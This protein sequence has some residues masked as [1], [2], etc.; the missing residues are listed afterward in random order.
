MAG[1]GR[2]LLVA[3]WQ[4]PAQEESLVYTD[5]RRS[6]A[7]CAALNGHSL[8]QIR[9]QHIIVLGRRCVVGFDGLNVIGYTLNLSKSRADVPKPCS[10]PDRQFAELAHAAVVSV[11]VRR[12]GGKRSISPKAKT[13]WHALPLHTLRLRAERLRECYRNAVR[14]LTCAC[15]CHLALIV[16][17]IVMVTYV[18]LSQFTD[19]GIRTIKNSPQ[20]ASQAAELAKSFGCEMKEIYWTLGEY[21][22]VTVIEAPD[23]QSFMSFGYALGSAGNIRTQTL[24]AF[25]KDECSSIIGK[26]P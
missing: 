9:H 11:C 10:L 14:N 1:G 25:T 22:I 4:G 16:R 3:G 12:Q 24:R 21:D 15:E 26:L 19:Q 23:E 2:G 7:G 13:R 5:F 17:G 18:V 20:R 6:G 8:R